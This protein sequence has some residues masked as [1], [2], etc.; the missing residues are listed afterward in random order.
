LRALSDDIACPGN[1]GHGVVKI[2]DVA[3]VVQAYS[4]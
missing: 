2:L 4:M 1:A 3:I